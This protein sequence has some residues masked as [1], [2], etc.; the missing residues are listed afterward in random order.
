MSTSDKTARTQRILIVD[1]DGEL[2][3][4][5]SQYFGVNGFQVHTATGAAMMEQMLKAVPFDLVLLDLNLPDACGRTVC[6]QLAQKDGPRV[7]MTSASNDSVDR[8]LC[9]ELGADDYV[10]KPVDPRELL[11]RT[12]AVLRRGAPSVEQAPRAT[13][14]FHGFR[15]DVGRRLLH[16]P[17]GRALILRP[18]EV[19]VLSALLQRPGQVLS[20]D[21]LVELVCGEEPNVGERAI[22]TQIS[23]LRRK[24]Q[25]HGQ[26]A[27][28]RTV[29]GLGYVLDAEPPK[30]FAL[31]APA[32]FRY[33]PVAAS[34]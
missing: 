4:Q 2:R 5:L 14:E 16:T 15:F 31:Q 12:R 20:R 3:R 27:L 17:D 6:H 28:I 13:Y 26:P 19:A 24:L 8:I 18:Q 21:T 11:A 34:A 22:D 30:P 1:G 32:G 25:A 7:I 9:L 23:R 29:Y 10:V 33:E